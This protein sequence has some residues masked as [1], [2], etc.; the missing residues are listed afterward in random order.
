[1]GTKNKKHNT[2]SAANFVGVSKSTLE[3]YRETPG[4]GPRYSHN[5]RQIEYD[6]SDLI[7]WR[8]SRKITSRVEHATRK[9]SEKESEKAAKPQSAAPKDHRSR[10]RKRQLRPRTPADPD[11]HGFSDQAR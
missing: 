1:M 3:H 9:E 7:E 6:E 2:A 11:G 5:G 4:K 10:P 8:E